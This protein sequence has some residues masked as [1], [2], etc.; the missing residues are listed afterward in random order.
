MAIQHTRFWLNFP[1]Q[2]ITRPLIWELCKKFSVVTNI[3][4]ASVTDEIGIVSLSM[5]GDGDEIAKAVAWLEAEG[6]QVDPV[7]MNTIAS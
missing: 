2:H 6:V 1:P 7:E 4:Q 5:E 3:R